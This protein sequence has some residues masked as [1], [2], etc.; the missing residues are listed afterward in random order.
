MTRPE[1]FSASGRGE[2]VVRRS[3]ADRSGSGADLRNTLAG[4][5]AVGTAS[6]A[7]KTNAVRITW[8]AVCNDHVDPSEAA[9]E[10]LASNGFEV[11]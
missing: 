7:L 1:Q 4:A 6:F 2:E 3:G 10:E 9:T 5:A 11:H 8:R